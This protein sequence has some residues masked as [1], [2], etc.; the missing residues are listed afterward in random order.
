MKKVAIIGAGLTGLTTGLYLKKAGIPFVI[1]EKNSYTGGVIRSEKKKGFIIEKGPNTGVVASLELA[2]LLEELSDIAKPVFADERAK[3]RLIL[4]H[5]KWHALP[6]GITSAVST[7]LF[8]AKDKLKVAGEFFRKKGNYETESLAQTVKRRLGKSF[9]DYAIDPFVSGVYAGDPNYL[10]TKYA[11]P[12]LYNLEDKYGSFIKGSIK[13][14]K[15]RS[16]EYKEKVNK[17]IFSFENGLQE[18]TDA[19]TLKV[20]SENIRLNQNKLGIQYLSPSRFSVNGEEFTHIVSTVNT[21]AIDKLFPF[22]NARE[23]GTLVRLLYAPV[24]E[25]SL[26]FNHWEGINLDAFGGLIPTKENRN[27]LGV[28]FMSSQFPNRAPKEGA[29]FSVFTGGI[30][31]HNLIKLP[32]DELLKF[33]AEDFRE[34]MQIPAFTANLIEIHRHPQAIAQYG[35]DSKER[36]QE[37]AQ[38]EKKFP[39][40]LIK[41]NP[42]DGIGI[43]DRVT[44]AVKT[45]KKL[46]EK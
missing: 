2:Q 14:N 7:P 3:K 41:G 11:F 32:D 8:T 25:L 34:L 26:G 23:I 31:K 28:L 44:Q 17:K 42:K 33:V 13:I 46:I 12:K 16:P 21:Q 37:I 35:I 45:A 36:L 15:E 1:F 18:L 29:F 43:A 38:V 40:L 5:G 19:L 24:I 27:I 10:I 30:K 39:G 20:G 9:L 4:K 22:I 6:T